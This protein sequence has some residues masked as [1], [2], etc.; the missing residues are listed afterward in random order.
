MGLL[1]S[2]H[3]TLKWRVNISGLT[4]SKKLT[5]TRLTSWVNFDTVR[6][7][8]TRRKIGG[9]KTWKSA[10][11]KMIL[12]S[13]FLR[14]QPTTREKFCLGIT[15]NSTVAFKS[16]SFSSVGAMRSLCVLP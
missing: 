6:K 1:R 14:N 16:V 12:M 9:K 7:F 8:L 5:G 2:S 13:V 4:L 11:N 15:Y 10:S 3:T